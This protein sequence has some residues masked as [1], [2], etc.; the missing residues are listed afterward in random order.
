MGAISGRVR[1][2]VEGA[3]VRVWLCVG[4]GRM[5]YCVSRVVWQGGDALMGM[6][7]GIM[8]SGL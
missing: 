5:W 8:E 4:E 6:Q 3:G 1:G 2:R 7:G